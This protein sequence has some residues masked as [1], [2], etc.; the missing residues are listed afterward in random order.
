[1]IA[2]RKKAVKALAEAKWYRKDIQAAL[3]MSA[4]EVQMVLGKSPRGRKPA[5]AKTVTKAK[6]KRA[7]K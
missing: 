6:T 3:E 5:V 2:I 4:G 1:M 7:K